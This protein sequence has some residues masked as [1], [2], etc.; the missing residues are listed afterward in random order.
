LPL[1]E[2]LGGKLGQ[3]TPNGSD[4]L[5]ERSETNAER[6][7]GPLGALG[8]PLL[9]AVSGAGA[10]RDLLCA[11]DSPPGALRRLL[12]APDIPHRTLRG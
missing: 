5:S 10:F 9:K 1:S 8:E 11:S 7:I 3:A 2:E 6:R 12:Q 4:L